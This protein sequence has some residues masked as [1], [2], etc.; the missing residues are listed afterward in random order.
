MLKLQKTLKLTAASLLTAVLLAGQAGAVGPTCVQAPNLACATGADALAGP[1]TLQGAGPILFDGTST[2]DGIETTVTVTNPT[3][4]RTLTV[5]DAN[6]VAVVP[7][8]CGGG[9]AVTALSAGGVL[10]CGSVAAGLWSALTDPT[11]NLT[12]LHGNNTTTFT[13]G[14]ATGA[15]DLFTLQDTAANSGN[16]YLQRLR[17]NGASMGAQFV[18]NVGN[19][20]FETVNI[21][22]GAGAKTR[23]VSDGKLFADGMKAGSI[24]AVNG[25][26]N[27]VAV[28]SGFNRIV[29]PTA[30]F[31]ITGIATT[32][33]QANY[34]PEAPQVVLYNSVA[35]AMTIA[36][37]SASSTAA[38]R[39]LTNTGGDRTTTLQGAVTLVY[40]HG[41]S[42]WV[43][44]SFDP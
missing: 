36:N 39:I 10:T 2:G 19:D 1:F 24:A 5:P 12:L 4:D 37:D 7:V 31:T 14:T 13:W 33:G 30:V 38:N 40:S 44:T 25:A 20:G 42:R 23:S 18:G 11:G 22:A 6:C 16:G 43:V 34:T 17:V 28:L 15:S 29:G 8:A 41:D 26:N 35:F 21:A 27:N 32:I 3:V 9:T